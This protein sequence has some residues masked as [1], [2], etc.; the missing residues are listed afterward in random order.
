M[1]ILQIKFGFFLAF[2]QSLWSFLASFE[3]YLALLKF[4][5]GNPA[6]VSV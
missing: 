3:H 6:I 1:A 2:K 4:S 5:S